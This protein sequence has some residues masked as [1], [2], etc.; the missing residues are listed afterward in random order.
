MNGFLQMGFMPRSSDVA[1]LVLR[2]W[3]GLTLFAKHGLV[4]INH[5]SQMAPHF[6]DPL[7][8]GSHASLVIALIS[9]AVCSLLIVLG[10]AARWAA[11][12]VLVV[13][14]TAFLLVHHMRL[15]GTGSGELPFLFAGA[16][17]VVLIAGPG[18][19]SLDRKL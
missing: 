2:L 12:Y 6:P 17:L 1:L 19:F 11:L 13:L 8:F 3:F 14:G 9:D 4:K 16:A 10:L 7:H 18:R 5:F 15:S